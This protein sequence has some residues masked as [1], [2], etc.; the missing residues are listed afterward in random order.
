MQR[1]VRG[2]APRHL[3]P[4]IALSLLASERVDSTVTAEPAA[5]VPVNASA[6]LSAF[7]ENNL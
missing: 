2:L 7:T 1:R 4:I 6:R 3:E 5:I